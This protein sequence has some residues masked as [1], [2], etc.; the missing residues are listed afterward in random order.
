MKQAITVRN[1]RKSYPTFSLQN[2]TL[3]VPAG[4]ITGFIGPNGAGKTT[5][6][7]SLLGMSHFD[8]GD[9]SV[10]GT[11]PSGSAAVN[12]RL[13]IILDAPLYVD[14]WTAQDVESAIAPFYAQWQSAR[15]AELLQ[16][17]GIDR[18]K[19][20]KELSRGMKVKL[21]LAAALSHGADLLILD[22]PT[23]GLD[24]V[25]RN[26][27]C[28]LLQEFVSNETKSILFS[29]HITS[30]L[31]KIADYIVF[32]LNGQIIFSGE[33]DALLEKYMLVKGGT[34]DFPAL[35]PYIIGLREHGMGF[36][37]IIETSR[38]SMLPRGV[39]AESATLEEIIVFMG[40]RP[41]K[42]DTTY[43]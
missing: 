27:L 43:A 36:E 6:I 9:I 33:K 12:N 13:G 23:S 4:Y 29:T 11:D 22:E 17:F 28:D 1:L 26:E 2:V 8:S 38:A 40:H 42:E 3:D 16:R 34:D 18:R 24:P 32:I 35:K 39:L 31:E 15:F 25:A 14:D 21:T 30:D 20:V 19:K 37:G 10:L 7:K 5:V 41:G